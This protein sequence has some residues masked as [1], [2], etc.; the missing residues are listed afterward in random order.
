MVCA[1]VRL[2]VSLLFPPYLVE[3][4]GFAGVTKPGPQRFPDQRVNVTK[5]PQHPHVDGSPVAMSRRV[6]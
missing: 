6:A 2:R 3:P 4:L 5:T 1:S